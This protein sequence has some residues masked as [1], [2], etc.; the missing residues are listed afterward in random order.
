[1]KKFQLIIV[2]FLA[3]ISLNAGIIEKTF[4]FNPP[5]VIQSGD[6]QLLQFDETL[7]TGI[8][9]DP[10]LP[11]QS[12][13]LL[14]P[15]GEAAISV[16]FIIEEEIA[17]Q[18]FYQ[19]YPHQASKPLSFEGES[20]FKINRSVY[21]SNEFYPLNPGGQLTTSFLNGYAFAVTSF[22]PVRYNPVTGVVKFANKVKV[23][24]TS[25]SDLNAQKALQNLKS[26][27]S[28]QK[29]IEA[30][31]Q[32]ASNIKLYPSI[33]AKSDEY[34]L[35][36]ITTNQ[37]A[38]EFQIL[39]DL[40]L[41]RGIKTEIVTKETIASTMTGQDNQEKIRNYIIQEYQDNNIEFVLLGG[42]VEH[43]PHRGFYCYVESGSGYEDSD[44]PADLYY[45]ALDGNWNT[46][47]DNKWGEI[48]EDDLLPEVAVGRFSFSNTTELENMINKTSMY[49]N[50]PVLGEF[51]D[52][53]MAGEWLYSNPDT[54]GSDYLELLIGHQNENGYETWGI[55][56]T[57]DFE[58]LYE[59]NQGW[60]ANDLI[61][62][63]N[64]GK[65]FVHHVGHANSNYVAYMYNSDITNSNF[66]G[67]NGVDHNFTIMQSHGCICGAFDD[68]DCIMEKMVS[69]EN[70]AVAV[71]GNSR[72][73]WFNEGQTE[74]PAQH[75]HREMMDA[76]Y[77]EKMQFIGQ[78]FVESKIQTAPWVTAPGQWEEGALRWNFY[79]IN[80]LGD[81]TLS[82]WTAEPV[83][84]ETTYQ[85]AIPIG[86][87]STDVSVMAGGSPAENFSCSI[88]MDGELYG[89][90]YTDAS[91]NAQIF[92]DPVLTN[93][94]DAE[95]II[96]GNN[97]LPTVYPV[98]IIPNAGAYVVYSASQIDDSQGNG[99]G[100]ADF[101]ET[102][103]LG[104]DLEN[105]GEDE[106][107]N[108]EAT[109]STSDAFITI[110]DG[111]ASFGN[112][113]GNTTSS[114]ADAF[115]F[116]IASNIP[117]Q[118]MVAFDMEVVGQETWNSSF[119]III[120]APDLTIGLLLID[121]TQG[122][123]GDGILDPGETANI[124]VQ[125]SNLGSCECD[126]TQALLTSNSSDISI[127]NGTCNLGILIAGATINAE[128]TISVDAGASIGSGVDLNVELTSGDYAV[129]QLYFLTVGLI[130]EDFETGDFSKFSW[131]FDGDAD[132]QITDG[133]V[134]EG[135][136]SAKS[137]SIGDQSES[138]MMV[139]MNVMADDEISFYR[140][141]SSE[142]GYDYLR[143]YIDNVQLGEWAGEQ[144]WEMETFPVSEG[145][146]TFKWAYE[147]DYSVSGGDDCAWVD[148]IVF[149]GASGSGN[150]LSVNVSASPM[151]LCAGQ[152]TQ[153][154]AYAFGGTGNYTYS[155][156]PIT[157]L[158]DPSI[159]N[160]VATPGESITYTVIVDDGNTTV[161][162]EIS[163]TVY[164]VPDSPT[165][166]IEDDHLVS[167][168]TSGNQWFNSNGPISGAT[169][170]TYY[171]IVTDDY[172]VVVTN[173]FGC[174]SEESNS[175]YFLYTTINEYAKNGFNIYP[176]PFVD[177]FTVEY[178]LKSN[179]GVVLTLLNKLGQ[180]VKTLIS[181]SEQ[182]AGFYSLDF[183][184]PE[185]LPGIYFIRIAA[186][187][188]I[189][190]KKI[191]LSK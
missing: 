18:G 134:Y 155:W 191:V 99:N 37:F 74:G 79:D 115:S 167:T 113:A 170:Q 131:E 46:D 109:L 75:L 90:G 107:T 143:F 53:L 21:Q 7:N 34:Q 138:E 178:Q 112:I 124:L 188:F 43:I 78:A 142:E 86:V 171:P 154:N 49:Q 110:T 103:V 163:L 89:V 127:I 4:Y 96:S 176:N 140:K 102:I 73:G 11:Y 67:A 153:L 117:D 189:G 111:N 149:P 2:L 10:A 168:A 130:F 66:S 16:E 69:I 137:G 156:E 41:E 40:Y 42:D 29:R 152:S 150:V 122:G 133:E 48:G 161:S 19:L 23:K 125:S 80:I 92:F 8:A 165:I 25:A 87:A 190:T 97:C 83:S 1:M 39:A 120:N 119:T 146:H 27:T 126:N 32:N 54:Y 175:I 50:D 147:K 173:E 38:T 5:G 177:H 14:L 144:N 185:L 106:A 6:Y 17:L 70:F 36:I 52:A 179:S 162:G 30:F 26:S 35:L 57:Y 94:G 184:T 186:D 3:A 81:P 61:Q 95:L 68:S 151:V 64:S 114:L 157:G 77:H 187:D 63:I 141:V 85:N 76:I 98:T 44:I 12:V 20:E 59:V 123:N 108:V 160:P 121:D 105:V 145:N 72:Y 31:A 60:G 181:N 104:I 71:I 139:E 82:V 65:Q 174:P 164:P 183:N 33:P 91:G 128:F 55:P 58:K 62:A 136:Y 166:S 129:Q 172:Y 148:Y 15:P 169:G 182:P 9:G 45:S 101:G 158:N 159:A 47:N 24:I 116:D 100:E 118:H 22:T 13:K 132:W 93:V 51:N 84:I 180:E 28:I 88:L 135:T 56:E